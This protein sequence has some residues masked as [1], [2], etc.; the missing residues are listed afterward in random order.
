[1]D[2][3]GD[4]D[5]AAGSPAFD[6]AVIA[7]PSSREAGSAAA[8]AANRRLPVLYV[9]RNSVPQ[10]TRDALRD[11]GINRTLVI[12][13]PRVVSQAVLRS[14]PSPKRLGGRDEYATSRA[15]VA[16]SRARG[17]P[18]NIGYVADGGGSAAFMGA[19]VARL[20]GL[21]MLS[22][23]PQANPERIA[24]RFGLSRVTDRLV[25]VGAQRASSASSRAGPR[26]RL[27]R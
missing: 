10:P 27:P 12:G 11:L 4:A 14:L 18:S 19:A 22:P 2:R 25:A 8:L 15:V 24:T 3:R 17:L 13:G 23:N 16:E 21:L 5:R 20:G 9:G 7:N 26:E 1:M 6:A